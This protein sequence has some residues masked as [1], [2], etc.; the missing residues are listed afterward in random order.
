MGS[1]E[2]ILLDTHVAVWSVFD[3]NALGKSCR[4]IVRRASEQHEL[5]VS[6][7]SFWEIALLIG[8][9]RLR[10]VDSAKETRR[11]I[12]SAGTTELPLT[13]EI[14]ILAGELEG[15]HSDPADRSIAA[16]AIAHGATLVTAD[17]RLLQWRHSLRRHN[18]A[19]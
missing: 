16:T 3:N 17:D 8:K 9:R 7:I 6:A 2:V 14:A 11:L 15:L 1:A 18:A 5:A 13:G 12:L 19:T 4:R 10:L